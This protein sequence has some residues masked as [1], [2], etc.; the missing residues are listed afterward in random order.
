MRLARSFMV[1]S[2]TGMVLVAALLLT[3][4]ATFKNTPRQDYAYA[5]ARQCEG[6]VAAW[7]IERVDVDGHIHIHGADTTSADAFR[8]CLREQSVREPYDQWVLTHWKDYG[9]RQ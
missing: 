1:Q 7:K 8:S 6:R 9:G 5:M 4:C 3:S 2:R